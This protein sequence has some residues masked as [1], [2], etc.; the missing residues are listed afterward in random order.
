MGEGTAGVDMRTAERAADERTPRAIAERLGTEIAV[1]RDELDSLVAELDRR[2]HNA[3]DL[4]R[5]LERHAFGVALTTLALLA[6]A[7]G[8]V[9]FG[10]WRQRRWVRL[11]AQA[12]RLRH[13]IARMT[14]HPERV[15]AEPTM[16]GKIVT[17]AASAAVAALV[18]K[19]L[20]RAV[21]RLLEEKPDV[22]GAAPSAGGHDHK[23]A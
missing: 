4:R 16:A 6:T 23:A 3:L 8:T 15:A 13:A 10:I 18:K 9:S 11:P 1:V 12:G 20:E 7:T 5:Q 21:Q 22:A 17:A 2:R 19:L 14:E